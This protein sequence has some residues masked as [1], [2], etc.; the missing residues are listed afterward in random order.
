MTNP[1]TKKLRE[2]AKAEIDRLE[3]PV[4]DHANM[5]NSEI[6]A[7]MKTE[8]KRETPAPIREAVPSWTRADDEP[9]P[10]GW[11]QASNFDEQGGNN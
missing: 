10:G 11:T 6:L 8:T 7:Y 9:L 1:D 4:P 5:T 3:N 2:F